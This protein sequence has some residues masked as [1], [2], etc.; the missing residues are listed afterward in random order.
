M[1]HPHVVHNLCLLLLFCTMTVHYNHSMSRCLKDQ[2]HLLMCNV[3]TDTRSK[4][5]QCSCLWMNECVVYVAVLQ[6]VLFNTSHT[7]TA[8]YFTWTNTRLQTCIKKLASFWYH[9]N[10]KV[11]SWIWIENYSFVITQWAITIS[12]FEEKMI[13]SCCNHISVLLFQYL[14]CIEVL[15][16]MRSL[17]FTTR[18]QITR[19]NNSV[20]L[21]TN[22]NI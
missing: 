6:S 4:W 9:V 18:S 17:D 12:S 11:S 15:R 21:S 5:T 10:F 13:M 22:E 3:S 16:S 20:C 19:Y 14:G 2:N 8:Q 1:N 7:H